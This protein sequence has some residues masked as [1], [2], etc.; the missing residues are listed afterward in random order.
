MFFDIGLPSLIAIAALFL[1]P[2]ALQAQDIAYPPSAAIYNVVTD[3]GVDNTGKTDVT[4]KLQ[5]ILYDGTNATGR[6][7]QVIYF[8]KG[9]YLVSGMLRMK[10]DT[11]RKDTSHSHGPWLVGENRSQTIIRLKDNI[12]P[13]AIYNLDVTD[14]KPETKIY[15]QVVL[16]TGDS[17]N[18]TF[19][20]II[21]N[22]TVNVGS[23]NHGAI[24]LMYNTSNTGYLGEVDII[25]ED[26]AGLAGLA[27]AGV[28]NGPGQIRNIHVKGFDIGL[29]NVADYVTASTGITLENARKVGLLNHGNTAG[30]DFTITM[31]GD[32]PA[33]HNTSRGQISLIG[34][35][36]TAKAT[37]HPAIL[38]QGN[39]YLR[40]IR[41]Q[42]FARAILAPN[43]KQHAPAD[44]IVDEYYTGTPV[45]LFN[46]T[47]TALRL[48]IKPQPEV[49]YEPDFAKWTS[50]MEHGAVGDGKA[51]DSQAVQKALND[52]GKTHIVIPYGKRF[53]IT[54]PLTLGPDV[55]RVLGTH[56]VMPFSID[57]KASLTI[58]D[59]KA[60]VVI[61][62]GLTNC[63]P[64]YVRTARTVVLD[65]VRVKADMP[66]MPKAPEGQPKNLPP[67][68]YFIVG[69][70]L[71]G[72]GDVFI[73]NTGASMII[74][75]PQQRVWM[76]HYNSEL[77]QGAA[78]VP[79]EVKAGTLWVLGWKSENL[80]QRVRIHKQ[81]T[82]EMTGYNNY[83]VSNRRQKDGDWP[84]F[85]IID[86]RFSCNLLVQHG[87]Q[88]NR[89]LIWETRNGVKRALT[90]ENNPGKRDF[91]LYT[92]YE[93]QTRGSSTN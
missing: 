85:E 89:N 76:R 7:L 87:S 88:A 28:E 17:T 93:P 59:G 27:L 10:L 36:L 4:E 9:T 61:I 11:S 16:S 19:N 56:G 70:F 35:R 23:G 30:E 49:P 29:Y 84:I 77:G 52:P 8:P 31:A 90:I 69:Y 46:N 37:Q 12:W 57:D 3:G 18:T 68:K 40:D 33:I 75:N 53:R 41:S 15:E 20:K 83:E 63:P 74:D 45:G 5:K 92:G 66:E 2:L 64:I 25:S 1:A 14:A 71:M 50:P 54:Q 81:G 91:P 21:R 13:K 42:G 80:V 32:G 51:D 67:S 44:A 82:M 73:N 62:E 72:S 39:A 34:A 48:P 55:V 26:G 6:R 22:L 24:G 38:T 79:I 78:I 86:G 58:G 60:S 47:K 43:E 65:S